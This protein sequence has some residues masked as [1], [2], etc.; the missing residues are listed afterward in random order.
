VTTAARDR[1]TERHPSLWPVLHPLQEAVRHYSWVHTVLGLVGNL[2]FLV[3]SVLFFWESTKV[4]GVWLFVV[5]A[6][7]MLVGSVGDALV[8]WRH[9]DPG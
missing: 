7:G 3:G 2:S 5:G 8:K 9:D 1:A 4:V 6:A